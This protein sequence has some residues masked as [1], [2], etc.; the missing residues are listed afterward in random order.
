MHC[1]IFFPLGTP[2]SDSPVKASS[3][4]KSL[5]PHTPGI[6]PV[7]EEEEGQSDDEL[8]T[9]GES[10]AQS[11]SDGGPSNADEIHDLINGTS[12]LS[13]QNATL[14]SKYQ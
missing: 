1:I 11:T 2:I 14:L 6:L 3:P 4:T 9:R 7:V 5:Y 12:G 10:E 8:L 13:A